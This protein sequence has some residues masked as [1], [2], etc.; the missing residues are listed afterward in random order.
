[1]RQTHTFVELELSASA[2]EEIARKLRDA[3]YDHA[4]VKCGARTVIDMQGIA[5]A[6]EEEES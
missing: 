4:F 1:M 6:N 3:E 5:V 2:Y